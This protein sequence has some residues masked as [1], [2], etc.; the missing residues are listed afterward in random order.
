MVAG[1]VELHAV[2][3]AHVGAAVMSEYLSLDQPARGAPVGGILP[4]PAAHV[5]DDARASGFGV[6]GRRARVEDLV[7][8]AGR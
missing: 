6:D 4:V 7:D 8:V 3:V 2:A 1:A 5:V